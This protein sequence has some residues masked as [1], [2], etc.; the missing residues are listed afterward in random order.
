MNIYQFLKT[1]LISTILMLII[2][3]H[4]S[5]ETTNPYNE[6]HYDYMTKSTDEILTDAN[7]PHSN[8]NQR[9]PIK[10]TEVIPGIFVSCGDGSAGCDPDPNSICAII[11]TWSEPI[12]FEEDSISTNDTTI[13]TDGYF[14]KALPAGPE[15]VPF[16]WL[17]TYG[18]AQAS[19]QNSNCT[20]Y[21]VNLE[22]ERRY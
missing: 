9:D 7:L 3:G 4:S 6:A 8:S 12:L 19:P 20:N 13:Y 10:T 5:C 18:H 21:G 15:A 11:V 22:Y 16:K 17:K 1:V 14:V 2:I